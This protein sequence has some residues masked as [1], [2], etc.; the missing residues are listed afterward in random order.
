[1]KFNFVLNTPASEQEAS[2]QNG[3]QLLTGGGGHSY[4]IH[5]VVLVPYEVKQHGEQAIADHIAA[6]LRN[7]NADITVVVGPNDWDRK[8]Q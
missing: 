6:Q 2:W 4:S 5:T 7:G 1:M 3:T 8:A